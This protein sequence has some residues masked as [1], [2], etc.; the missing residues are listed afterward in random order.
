MSSIPHHKLIRYW[1]ETNLNIAFGPSSEDSVAA[2]EKRYG[3]AFPEDFRAYLLEVSLEDDQLDEHCTEW[4]SLQRIK[5]I[6]DEYE[7]PI[8]NPEITQDSQFYIF[9]A[10]YMFW[11]WAWAICCKPGKNYGRIVQIGTDRF[12]AENFAEFIDFYLEGAP[13]L[14]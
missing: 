1:E 6:P 14:F 11:C 5:N 13:E 3:I 2:L 8:E 4:W 10:D 7:Y 12:V 9:F